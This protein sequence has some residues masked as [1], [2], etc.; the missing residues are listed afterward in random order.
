MNKVPQK[1]GGKSK[2]K[3]QKTKQT[4]KQK[5]PF[6]SMTGVPTVFTYTEYPKVTDSRVTANLLI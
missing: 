3:K 4:N 1:D 2:T 5:K 6:S